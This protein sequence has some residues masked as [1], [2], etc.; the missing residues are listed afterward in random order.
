MKKGE[1]LDNLRKKIDRIDGKLIDFLAQRLELAGDIAKL[2]KR[3]GKGL[4]DEVREQEII[5][6]AR[7]RARKKGL[8]PEFVE[9]LLRLTMAQMAGIERE[10]MEEAGMWAEVQTAFAGHPAQLSVAR[11]LLRYGLRVREKGEIACGDIRIP[12]V[13]IAK[14][15][16]VDRRVVDATAKTVL[17]NKKLGS[18]FS[19]LQPVCYLKG[20]AQ[21]LKLGVIEILPTDATQPGIISEVSNT[22]S[23]FG[24]SI[25]QSIADDPY[26]IAQ[27]KLTIITDKPVAGKVIEALR[28]L[29]TVRSV[30]V[31]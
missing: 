3:A 22:I 19:N 27:P 9:S 14:E 29:P 15:A 31:Y 5:E 13:Q 6:R 25:R 1:K 2:K 8:E 10:Q 26:F 23:K 7:K 17:K 11:I 21:Q 12:A 30:I 20:V 4:H 18:I 16:G 24:V 28:K